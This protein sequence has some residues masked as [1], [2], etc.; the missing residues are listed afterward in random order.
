MTTDVLT[1][2]ADELIA[3]LTGLD[4]RTLLPFIDPTEQEEVDALVALLRWDGPAT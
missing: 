2:P 4:G 1:A 3:S